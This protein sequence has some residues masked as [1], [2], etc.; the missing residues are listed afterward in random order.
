[1]VIRPITLLVVDDHQ[2]VRAGIK[3][4]LENYP[5]FAIVAEAGNSQD[6]LRQAI[7]HKPDVVLM[8]VRLPGND[9]IKAC[10]R[11]L[12]ELPQTRVIILTGLEDETTLMAAV[13]AGAV[14]YVIKTV[15]SGPLISAIK[16]VAAGGVTIDPRLGVALFENVRRQARPTTGVVALTDFIHAAFN[17]AELEYLCVRLTINYD[18]L[19]GDTH[20]LKSVELVLY[21]ER[22]GRLQELGEMV[23]TL[24]PHYKAT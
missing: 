9:G 1:M 18:D 19:P 20:Q 10:R 7:L 22:H 16:Q 4:L 2:L 23:K 3:E 12:A 6:A 24:R 11:I 17:P 21:C 15:E 14:G 8:D 13:Q 5:E